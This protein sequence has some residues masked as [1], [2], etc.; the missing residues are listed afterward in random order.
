LFP[1]PC[2]V[3][4]IDAD[5]FRFEIPAPDFTRAAWIC[6]GVF[7]PAASCACAVGHKPEAPLFD[8]GAV[9]SADGEYKD[10]GSLMR[11]TRVGCEYTA[12]SRIVAEIG[13]TPENGAHAAHSVVCAVFQR[14]WSHTAIGIPKQSCDVFEPNDGGRGFFDDAGDVGPYPSFVGSAFALSG[15]RVGLT[16]EARREDM[17]HSTPRLAVK[18]GNVV[19]LSEFAN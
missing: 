18:G 13:Q 3:F 6:S 11:G 14:F 9:G 17:K 8:G 5:S 19:P 16:R 12:P 7:D 15:D 2:G 1:I 4:H 10:S